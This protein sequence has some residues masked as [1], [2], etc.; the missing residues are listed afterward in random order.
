M[1]RIGLMTCYDLRFPELG[2]EL[3]D[4]GAELVLVCSSWVPGPG[5]PAQSSAIQRS[6]IVAT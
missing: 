1:L 3:A 6:I 4:A 2:R 5:T